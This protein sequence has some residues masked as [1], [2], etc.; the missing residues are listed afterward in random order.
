V[1]KGKGFRGKREIP[2][3]KKKY[4]NSTRTVEHVALKE[5]RGRD[6]AVD[7]N[8]KE[9]LDRREYRKGL[10]AGQSATMVDIAKP[11]K[12]KRKR[13]EQPDVERSDGKFTEGKGALP[14]EIKG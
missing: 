4:H 13:R 6:S 11:A 3:G 12:G 2:R 1:Q 9:V 10:S 8:G 14:G 5:G 7:D